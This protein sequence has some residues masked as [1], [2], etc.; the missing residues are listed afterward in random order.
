[1]KISNEALVA[2]A[3]AAVA[4]RGAGY[5]D[6]LSNGPDTCK[7]WNVGKNAPSCLVATILFNLGVA[8]RVELVEADCNGLAADEIPIVRDSFTAE[9]AR[10]LVR[11]QR[12]QDL[13]NSWGVAIAAT[14]KPK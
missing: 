1:M 12:L 6:P 2:A 13:G 4:E 7:Y 9:A 11:L 5:V 8:G 3:R 14:A 10:Y